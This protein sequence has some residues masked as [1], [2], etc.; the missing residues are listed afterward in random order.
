MKIRFHGAIDEVTGSCYELVDDVM[1]LHIL[2]D[3]GLVQGEHEADVRNQ[4]PFPF[5][6]RTLT[7]V[8]L[9]HAHSDH[10]GLVPRLYAGGYRG[11]VYCTEETASL[12][13]LVQSDSA[14][15]GLAPYSK[16]DVDAQKFHEPSQATTFRMVCPIAADF[17][18][19]FFRSG[20][21]L[22]ATSIQLLW[23]PR[24]PNQKAITFSADVGPNREDEEVFPLTAFRMNPYRADYLVVESTYGGTVRESITAEDRIAKL[25]EAVRHAV[26]ERKGTLIIPCFALERLPDVLCDLTFIYSKTPSLMNS[27]PVTVDSR[28]GTAAM[29]VMA[30]AIGRSYTLRDGKRVRDVWLGR[31]IFRLLGLDWQSGEHR[32]LVLDM[33]REMLLNGYEAKSPRTAAL[34]HWRRIWTPGTSKVGELRVPQGPAIVLATGGMCEGGPVQFYLR[35]L[36]TEPTTTVLFPGFCGPSTIGG[37]L[38]EMRDLDEAQRQ[39]LGGALELD[40]CSVNRAEIRAD[41]QK[42][43]GYSAHA[44]QAGLLDWMWAAKPDEPKVPIAST[45]FVSHG[46]P[47]PRRKLKSAIEE[48]A[49]SQGHEVTV[50]LPP[51]GQWYDLDAGCWLEDGLS[52]VEVM[53]NEVLRLRA[54]N[55]RLKRRQEDGGSATNAG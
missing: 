14:K 47:E 13:K 15:L 10:S 21:M 46:T 48:K 36:L 53:R 20:H 45:I 32:E 38:L 16:K 51:R 39:R 17:F 4:R 26:V 40:G 8:F 12:A 6:P 11:S 49:R 43:D 19:I 27:I 9:T 31:G 55:A 7:H 24:G 54:E 1:K 5:D 23:G 44:D 2:V 50:E 41:I 3:C 18:A 28:L 29:R 33:V 35:S 25:E 22:G 37:K 30:Q 52:P 42:I 34:A